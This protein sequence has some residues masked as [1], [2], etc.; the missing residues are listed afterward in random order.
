MVFDL[1]V[2]KTIYGTLDES[3]YHI[4]FV[5]IDDNTMLANRDVKTYKS[6]IMDFWDLKHYVHA[7]TPFCEDFVKSYATKDIMRT[8]SCIGHFEIREVMMPLA[9]NE[10][11]SMLRHGKVKNPYWLDAD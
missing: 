3:G 9:F 8:M 2:I 10:I 6:Y 1:K 7:E 4:W 5:H 11:L